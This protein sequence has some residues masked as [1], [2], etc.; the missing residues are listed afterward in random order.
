MRYESSHQ[1]TFY[2]Y[3]P[4]AF[5]LS[6]LYLVF[7][8]IFHSAFYPASILHF[9]LFY[10][11]RVESQIIFRSPI[12]RNAQNSKYILRSFSMYGRLCVHA[13]RFDSIPVPFK[14]CRTH[15]QSKCTITILMLFLDHPA[16][17]N[18]A[19]GLVSPVI[20]WVLTCWKWRLDASRGSSIFL[21]IILDFQQLTSSPLERALNLD[22]ETTWTFCIYFLFYW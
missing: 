14:W 19:L 2:S 7:T 3:H 21:Y 9:N 4:M 16:L 18:D 12:C 6:Y 10:G 20:S 8:P 13:C 5:L 11:I 17:S 22:L 1:I 15:I